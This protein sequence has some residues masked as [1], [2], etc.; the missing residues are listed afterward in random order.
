MPVETSEIKQK[1]SKNTLL[2]KG[3]PHKIDYGIMYTIDLNNNVDTI[4]YEASVQCLEIFPDNNALFLITRTSKTY[5]NDVEPDLV[6]DVLATQI[7]G[8]LYPIILKVNDKGEI[9][10][11]ENFQAIKDRW[12]AKQPEILKYYQGELVEKYLH[13]TG[14]SLEDENILLHRLSTDWFLCTYFNG[15]YQHHISTIKTEKWI[16]FPLIGKS[17]P[18]VFKA[19]QS[20]EEYYTEDNRLQLNING[21]LADE[22]CKADLENELNFPYF[23]MNGAMPM[24]TGKYKAQYY[25]DPSFH[26]VDMAYLECEIDLKE[27]KRV[28]VLIAS[29]N[30]PKYKLPNKNNYS[31]A[32]E[33][34]I[35]KKEKSFWQT[36]KVK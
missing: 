22:R 1:V 24:A 14:L 29:L 6:A 2:Y 4:K 26:A 17:K 5:I 33:E 11:I 21:E 19:T 15:I 18:V 7:A 34:V 35:E 31:F 13:L 32:T 27:K 3:M 28:T 16:S 12:V 9:F 23:G 30:A 36:Q 10:S 8:I 25:L 20:I